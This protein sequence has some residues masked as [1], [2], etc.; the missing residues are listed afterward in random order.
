MFAALLGFVVAFIA[1]PIKNIWIY[2]RKKKRLKDAIYKE[3]ITIYDALNFQ[4]EEIDSPKL[5]EILGSRFPVYSL[6]ESEILVFHDMRESALIEKIYKSLFRCIDMSKSQENFDNQK[7]IGFLK[8]QIE[9]SL[10]SKEFD[11][12]RVKR[13]SRVFF[14]GKHLYKTR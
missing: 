4:I 9:L 7:M 3:I 13:L 14:Y 12:R 8:Q 1:D 5:H 11:R 2:L 6:L 10:K